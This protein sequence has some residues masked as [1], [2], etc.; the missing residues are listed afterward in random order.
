MHKCESDNL[1]ELNHIHMVSSFELTLIHGNTSP[2]MVLVRMTYVLKHDFL[3][4]RKP[5]LPVSTITE[6]HIF[7]IA[8]ATE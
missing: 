4:R 6:G 1:I 5:N 7:R 8:A 3:L 2:S